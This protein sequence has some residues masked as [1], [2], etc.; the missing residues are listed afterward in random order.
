MFNFERISKLLE[1]SVVGKNLF[2][3]LRLEIVF[4]LYTFPIS[5]SIT[6]HNN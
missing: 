5:R 6:E 3:I 2:S 1:G 4:I